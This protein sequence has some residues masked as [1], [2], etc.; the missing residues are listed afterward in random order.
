VVKSGDSLSRISKEVY[1]ESRFA[2]L[3]Y[4]ANRDQ[5]VNEHAIQ[6]GQRLKIPPRPKQ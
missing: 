5:L 4:E 2:N 1:G 6:I 3:I